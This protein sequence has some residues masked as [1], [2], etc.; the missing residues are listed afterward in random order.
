MLTLY[1]PLTEL[2]ENNG[3]TVYLNFIRNNFTNNAYRVNFSNGYCRPL[4]APNNYDNGNNAS[5]D[6]ESNIRASPTAHPK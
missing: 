4:F 6:L 3:A 5:S 2:V 1:I